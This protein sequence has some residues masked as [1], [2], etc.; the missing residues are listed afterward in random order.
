[1]RQKHL[2]FFACPG[3]FSLVM[4]I[5]YPVSAAADLTLV[6]PRLGTIEARL[7]SSETFDLEEAWEQ[8]SSPNGVELGIENG[9]YRAY[10]LN[11]GFVWALN[12]EQHSDVVLAVE[13]TPLTTQF[14]N[15][16]GIMCR[17][18]VDNNGDGYYFMINANGYYSIRIGQ[19]EDILPLVDWTQSDMVH[20]EIDQNTIGAVCIDDKLAMYVNGELLS[21]IT[22]SNYES[23]FTGIAIAAAPNSDVDVAFDNL[24]IYEVVQ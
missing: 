16:Y 21:E 7:L 19:G 20:P 23:G 17:A 9:V 1:M 24:M 4:L 11:E 13:V 5:I 8:Y 14:G 15:A 22:D 12:E 18:D 10:T 3:I 2:W 6:L